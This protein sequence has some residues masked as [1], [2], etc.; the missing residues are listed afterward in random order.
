MSLHYKKLVGC[1]YLEAGLTLRFAAAREYSFAS[2]AEWPA[3]CDYSNTVRLAVEEVLVRQH[4]AIPA[5][6]VV[7]EEIAFHEIHSSQVAFKQATMAAVEAAY[8]V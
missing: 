6:A 3:G 1:R 7:L 4:G 8:R 2:T 5:I